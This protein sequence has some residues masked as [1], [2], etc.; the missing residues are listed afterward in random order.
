MTSYQARC[1]V[2]PATVNRS[3]GAWGKMNRTSVLG[4]SFNLLTISRSFVFVYP[5]VAITA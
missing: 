3:L 2:P 4:G 1:T 5:L